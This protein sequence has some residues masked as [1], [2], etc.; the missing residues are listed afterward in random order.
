MV[1]VC[2]RDGLIVGSY[3]ANSVLHGLCQAGDVARVEA[4]AKRM[5]ATPGGMTEYQY[6]QII[7][8]YC[9]HS[10]VIEAQQYLDEMLQAGFQ[11]NSQVFQ[12]VIETFLALGRRVDAS[13]WL[14]RMAESMGSPQVRS[15][16]VVLIPAS[17]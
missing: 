2:L 1:A 4:W 6:T 5:R 11:A 17:G 7:Q 15:L 9:K 16:I 12:D 10:D 13:E 14:N 3:S 8:M